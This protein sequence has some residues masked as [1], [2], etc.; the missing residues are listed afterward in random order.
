MI[1][2]KKWK[3][4]AATAMLASSVVSAQNYPGKPI[5]LIVPF[6][7]GGGFDAKIGRAHV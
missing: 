4:L 2:S 1:A 7:P 6:P 5:R 3:M